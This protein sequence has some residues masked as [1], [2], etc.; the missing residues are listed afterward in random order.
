M[1]PEI[2]PSLVVIPVMRCHLQVKPAISNFMQ[3]RIMGVLSAQI[4]RC[5]YRRY[6][7]AL[8]DSLASG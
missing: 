7:I 1:N 4:F 2:T 8:L 6:A 3:Y 5:E